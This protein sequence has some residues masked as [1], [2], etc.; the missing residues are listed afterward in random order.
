MVELQKLDDL[1]LN[2]VVFEARRIKGVTSFQVA[3]SEV[4]SSCVS[5]VYVVCLCIV[6]S[7]V[8]FQKRSSMEPPMDPP[9]ES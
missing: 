8:A 5:V 7:K 6:F 1:Q 2:L 3:E 4:R 9:L